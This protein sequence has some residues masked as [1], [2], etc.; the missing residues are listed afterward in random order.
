MSQDPIDI[1]AKA[2]FPA[3]ALSNF[4][5]YPFT[6]DGIACQSMEGFLQSLKVEDSAE[7]VIVCSLVGNEAQAW[8][9]SKDWSTGTL[10]WRGRPIDRLSDAYQELL[11]RAYDALFTQSPKFRKALSATADARLIHKIGKSDP[12]ET[13]LTEQEFCGRLERLRI[14]LRTSVR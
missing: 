9:R 3:G 4:A 14:R 2:P 10:W 11:D 1:K 12:C 13:I 7:Q 6:L 5:P 8:G